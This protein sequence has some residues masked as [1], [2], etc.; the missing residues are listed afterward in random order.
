MTQVKEQKRADLFEHARPARFADVAFLACLVAVGSVLRLYR[1]ETDLWLDEIVT[2]VD[3]VRSPLVEII[4]SF[5]SDNNHPLYSVLAHIATVTLGES[6]WAL[7]LPA[8]LL[9]IASI[10]LLYLVGTTVTSR[11]EAAAA[12]SILSVSYHHIWFSQNARG[13]TL[14][15]VC[16]LLATWAL[17]RWLD[18]GRRL[19]L[20]VYAVAISAGCYAH[21]SMVLVCVS[22]AIACAIEMLGRGRQSRPGSE[23]ITLV[24]AFAGSALLTVLLYAPMLESMRTTL[25]GSAAAESMSETVWAGMAAAFSGLQIGF[26]SAWVLA[27]GAAVFGAGAW[28]YFRQRSIVA[29]LFLLPAPVVV[30]ASLVMGRPVRP[31]FA[32]FAIGFLLLVAIRGAN[33]I[34]TLCARFAIRVTPR[35]G[36]TI[37]VTAMTIGA[38]AVSFA[39]LPYGYRYPKQDYAG[40]IAFVEG[41]KG[42]ADR[43]A[44]IGDPGSI[45]A[46]RY[47]GKPWQRVDRASQFHEMRAAGGRIWVVYSFPSSIESTFPGLWPMLLE[48]VLVREFEGTVDDGTIGVR[49]CE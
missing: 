15:L 41:A 26:G 34:G 11:L 4:H 13:Y 24:A 27:A 40:A 37:L 35:Q 18:S 39:S 31:R 21:L 45:P 29:L 7:R 46:L 5:P 17:I 10:P 36:G 2:L 48:C 16:A 49:R 19:F 20:L 14:L 25:E 23:P 32:F 9:G 47:Y 44:A 22:H 30:L 1:L 43:V 8:A 6:P 28:A 3:F 38:I 42:A 12:T 33:S